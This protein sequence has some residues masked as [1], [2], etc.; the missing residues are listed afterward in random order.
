[1]IALTPCNS[2]AIQ[3]FGYDPTSQTLA[4][5]FSATKVHHYSGVSP[6]LAAEF[7]AAES[8]GKAYGSL[9]RG[10]FDAV[11]V[12]DEPTKETA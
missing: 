6:E 12:L 11:P 1:M 10:K 4:L 2:S 5:R 3:A 8:K 9:I 7:E